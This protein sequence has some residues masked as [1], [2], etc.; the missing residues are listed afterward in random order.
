MCVCFFKFKKKV[1]SPYSLVFTVCRL[2]SPLHSIPSI[3]LNAK[4]IVVLVVVA[5]LCTRLAC[6]NVL[7]YD[8]RFS[9]TQESQFLLI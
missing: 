1:L 6:P 8:M 2:L 5:F 4:F 9:R 7:Y 3:E